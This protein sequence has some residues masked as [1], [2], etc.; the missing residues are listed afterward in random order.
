MR[1]T[2]R[3]SIHDVLWNFARAEF[4][5]SLGADRH[6][7]PVIP[8]RLRVKL[9]R[10]DR[11]NLSSDDWRRVEKGLLST[12]GTIV[13]PVLD[14]VREWSLVELHPKELPDL[15][16]MNLRIFSS[17]APSRRLDDFAAALDRGEFPAVWDPAFY[18]DLRARFDLR[19]MH[20]VPILVA[21]RRGGPYTVV[22]GTTRMSV[23]ASKLETRELNA[24][25][26]PAVLGLGGLLKGWEWL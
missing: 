4:E 17:V 13:K 19:R 12:R 14:R 8:E 5:D 21:A 16:V 15:R 20:G 18:R 22:E 23:M 10:G 1:I 26:V 11:R 25:A 9:T 7:Q 6:T 24:R 3:A 2:G